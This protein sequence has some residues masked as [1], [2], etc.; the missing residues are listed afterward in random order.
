MENGSRCVSDQALLA[1]SRLT[2]APMGNVRLFGV[3]RGKTGAREWEAC[4]GV[5]ADGDLLRGGLW[6]V[7]VALLVM[8]PGRCAA[9]RRPQHGRSARRADGRCRVRRTRYFVDPSC[10]P[11]PGAPRCRPAPFSP[12]CR[13]RSRH[14]VSDR[15]SLPPGRVP[16]AC[17]ARAPM[18]RRLPGEDS[19]AVR[20]T[21]ACQPPPRLDAFAAACWPRGHGQSLAPGPGPLDPLRGVSAYFCGLVHGRRSGRKSS[22]RSKRC[23]TYA[24]VPRSRCGCR[25]ASAGS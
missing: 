11:A 13:T 25:S 17:P 3:T 15:A 21:P 14:P 7:L 9:L 18:R 12:G 23:H 20:D 6:L 8:A 19:T 10:R 22:S 2:R 24:D 16:C 5:R 1:R 4:H